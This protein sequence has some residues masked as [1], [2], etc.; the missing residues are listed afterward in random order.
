MKSKVVTILFAM[1][2]QASAVLAQGFAGLGTDAEGFDIPQ[3][4]TPLIF[5]QDHQAHPS[6]RIEWWYLTANLK[7]ETGTAFGIQWTLFRSALAPETGQGW[8]TPQVWL[9]HAAVTTPQDHYYAERLARGGIGIAGVADAP[10]SA[11]IDDWAMTSVIAE[12]DPLDDIRLTANGA[13]FAY[14][15]R[16]RA[17]GPL[18]LHGDRGFSVK[19][20][21]GQASYYYS[22][23]HYEVSGQ[24]DLGDRMINVTGTG[25]LDREWSS[26]PL[27]SDQSGWDWFSLNFDSGEKLMA[28]RLR[29]D[30]SG[31]RSG[32]WI[33]RDGVPTP[34]GDGDITVSPI[35]VTEVQNRPVPTEWQLQVPDYDVDLTIT[36][37]NAQSWMGTSVPYW[38]GPVVLNGT[39]GGSGYLEMTGYE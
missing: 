24:L 16:L 23:P 32:S 8:N 11:F 26:Q 19:S 29:D 28:F 12:G 15:V 34:L 10:F 37:L 1:I 35:G 38:E 33:D 21:A 5:P 27:A 6:Y 22:Q 3:R 39:H 4:G 25:W 9:G 13:N 20:A 14:D 17:Q 18:V 2:L 31:F 30:A 36:A 7:D